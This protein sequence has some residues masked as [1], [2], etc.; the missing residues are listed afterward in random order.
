MRLQNTQNEIERHLCIADASPPCY[1]QKGFSF[2]L[3]GTHIYKGGR[4]TVRDRLTMCAVEGGANLEVG[5]RWV[6]R[7]SLLVG[8]DMHEQCAIVLDGLHMHL[9]QHQCLQDS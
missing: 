8:D 4:K 1:S 5:V 7:A 9:Q 6:W 3:A 2:R